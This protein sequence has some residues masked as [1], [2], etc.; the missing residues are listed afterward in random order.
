MRGCSADRTRYRATVRL[1]PAHAGLFRPP[2]PSWLKTSA[3][4]A[5][6]GLILD[7]ALNAARYTAYSR[8][9]GKFDAPYPRTRGVDPECRGFGQAAAEFSPHTRGCSHSTTHT[10]AAWHFPR[11]CGVVPATDRP[12]VG[13]PIFPPA[14]AGLFRARYYCVGPVCPLT[15]HCFPRHPRGFFL[16]GDVTHTRFPLAPSVQVA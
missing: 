7:S 10:K 5:Y 2:A 1:F 11:S 13:T 3:F 4:P 8:V 6:A 16:S 15:R 9:L 14:H 12:T